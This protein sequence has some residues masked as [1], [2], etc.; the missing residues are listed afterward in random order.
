[1]N[2]GT[3]VGQLCGKPGMSR[4]NYYKARTQRQRRE[5]D[6][7]L[8]ERLVRAE[9]A[10]QPR[11]GGKKLFHIL[12]PILAREGVKIGRDRF[13]QVLREKGLLLEK[14]PGVPRTTNSRHS[15]PV[16]HNLVKDMTLTGPNQAWAGDI[17]Y[18]RTDGRNFVS[19]GFCI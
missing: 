4:Q 7:G 11:L 15:L 5:A 9:R 10:T 16:F 14:L 17:T 3:K 12:G 8:I 1:M 19:F 6:S 13:F 2:Y 18:I